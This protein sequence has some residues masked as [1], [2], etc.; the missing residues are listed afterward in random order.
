MGKW[1]IRPL[2]QRPLETDGGEEQ[3]ILDKGNAYEGGGS[4]DESIKAYKHIIYSE[5]LSI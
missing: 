2:C 5:Y 4:G 3:V 1:A